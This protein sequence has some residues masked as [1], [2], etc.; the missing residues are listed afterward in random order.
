MLLWEKLRR[1]PKD[2]WWLYCRLM[3]LPHLLTILLGAY[4]YMAL[5]VFHI[6]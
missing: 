3:S 5:Y 6:L 4:V 2:E 1:V